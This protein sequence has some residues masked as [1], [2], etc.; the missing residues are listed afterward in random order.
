MAKD[1][2]ISVQSLLDTLVDLGN[3]SVASA[4]KV[5]TPFEQAIGTTVSLFQSFWKE[6]QTIFAGVGGQGTDAATKLINV[7]N[8]LLKEVLFP[9]G[10]VLAKI[11][12][13]FVDVV[14]TGV[15]AA[16]DLI[17]GFRGVSS[18]IAQAVSNIINMIPGLR[19]VVGLARGL[20]NAV[21]KPKSSD[22][23][24]MAWPEGVPKPG[25]PGMIG[26]ITAPSQFEAG[27]K[28]GAKGPKPPEDRTKSLLADLQAT[29]AI[30]DA[31]DRIRDLLFQ[32][33]D[34][35][36]ARAEL[37]KTTYDI[38]RDR[39]KQLE[40]GNYLSE[41]D[42]INKIAAA[43]TANAVAATED[44]IREIQQQRFKEELQAQEAVRNAIKPFTELRKQQEAQAQYA[45][46]YFRLVTEGMLPAEAERIA[47]FEQLAIQQTAA[48]AEQIRLTEG[49]ILEAKARGA[50]TVELDKQLKVY[51]DQQKAIADQVTAGP[52]AGLTP[53][54]RAAEAVAQLRG[55]LNALG[56]PVNAAV[57]GANAIGSAFQQAFQG[58][59]TGTM[60]AQEAL[61]SFFKSV[62]ESFVA[63]AAEIIAKQLTLI[64][65]QLVLKS[66][67]VVTGGGGG[68]GSGGG[69]SD[70][71]NWQQY[72]FDGPG[73]PFTPP[74]AFAEGGFVTSPTRAVVGEG[75]EPEYIIPASKMRTAMSRYAS[76]ARGSAVIPAGGDNGEMMGN[77]ESAAPG[78]IDVRY[79]VERIN[80]VDYVTADQFQAGMRQAAAQG[81]AQGEQ[82]TLRRLQ[83]SASTRRRL[84]V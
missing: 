29:I 45:K 61:A 79:T 48:V 3:A 54:Q 9:I 25:S 6:V 78:T 35:A 59:A 74:A 16:T 39:I 26:R 10:R 52:G 75:N 84:G 11:A 82:R 31:E 14:S 30:G 62:G 58:L 47:N 36:A 18:A 69:I 8:T 80:S 76:G 37:D 24:D 32:G 72:A 15:S 77:G 68:S 33:R 13:L 38:D 42:A 21:I 43:R 23:N 20:V 60:T 5:K 44:K 22:W 2:E 34:I 81:A 57:A 28:A 73:V 27:G 55:E 56:D 67:G 70:I 66:L 71:G 17:V 4:E 7:F 1:G 51:K 64:T 40:Q 50:S 49:A 63:M 83:N 65:L 46:T 12:A 41:K 19:T 53:E